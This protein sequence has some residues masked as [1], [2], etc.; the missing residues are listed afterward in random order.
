MITKR[1]IY[2]VQPS[3]Q[4][5]NIM[6]LPYAVSV[7]HAYVCDNI[8]IMQNFEFPE[9]IFEKNSIS[10]VREDMV[11]PYAVFFSCY[12]WNYEYNKALAQEIKRCH[13]KAK[14]VFGGHNVPLDYQRAFEELPFADYLIQG[15]GERPF[16]DLLLFFLKQKS[17]KDLYNIAYW[18]QGHQPICHLRTDYVTERF[19]SPYQ[20][21]LFDEIVGKYKHIYR[22]SATLETNRGCPFS[23][24]YCDWG[25]NKAKVRLAP[26]D[27][28]IRDIVWMSEHGI[29]ECYGADSNFGMFDRDLGFTEVLSECKE[30]N[31][32]PQTFYVSFSKNS[33]EMILKITSILKKAKMLQG[34]TLS[35]QSLNL[36][37]LEAIGRRNLDLAYFTKL[38]RQYHKRRIP[39]YS[40]LILGLPLETEDSFKNGMGTLMECGQHNAIDVYE[41]C[42]LPN[43]DLGQPKNIKQY[44]IV[45]RK[46]PFRRFDV[47]EAEEVQEYSHIVVETSTMSKKGWRECNLFLNAVSALHFGKLFHCVA[48]Y[49]H[50]EFELS[51]AD[52]YTHVLTTWRNAE[53]T[54]WKELV[55]R[56]EDQLDEIAAGR[57]NWMFYWA[58]QQI[59]GESFRGAIC[60]LVLRHYDAYLKQLR[61]IVTEFC[62]DADFAQQ[63]VRYQA[64]C[65]KTRIDCNMSRNEA[66]DYDFG[67]YFNALYLCEN[68]TLQKREYT[69]TGAEILQSIAC[70]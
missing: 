18:G 34:A 48:L 51:Y 68:A 61:Y 13:P 8:E 43:S 36:D 7:L 70:G 6:P 64:F 32:Y 37:T 62:H 40:E 53:G 63:L 56:I 10:Q 21:G 3:T 39:T 2:M 35:F 66:F 59:E 5:V 4:H 60:K 26:Q 17:K 52:I 22:F 46:M 15:E 38:M 12:I 44:G 11:E 54:V 58:K 45:E 14:I 28:I 57:K 41:C 42:I 25:L 69:I 30:K 27:Q 31:G 9:Y 47:K 20:Y 1:K 67:S 55:Q 65:I 19:V 50:K 16:E 24:A 29:H 23:C 33:D 49:L